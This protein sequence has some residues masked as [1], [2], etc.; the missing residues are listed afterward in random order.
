MNKSPGAV[1]AIAFIFVAFFAMIAIISYSSNLNPSD[2]ITPRKLE[3][4]TLELKYKCFKDCFENSPIHDS[5]VMGCDF[6]DESLSAQ[7]KKQYAEQAASCTD[8]CEKIN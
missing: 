8:I 2:D 7:F 1:W 6:S 3:A 4:Y 5:A